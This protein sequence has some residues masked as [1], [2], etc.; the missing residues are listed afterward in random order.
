MGRVFPVRSGVGSRRD[1]IQEDSLLS[2]Q[3]RDEIRIVKTG[4]E[5]GYRAGII[6]QIQDRNRLFS[7]FLTRYLAKKCWQSDHAARVDV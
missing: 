6:R 7:S 2:A 1:W 4:F 5:M 3:I